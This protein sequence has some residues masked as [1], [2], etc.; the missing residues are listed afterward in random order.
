M[1]NRRLRASTSV[2]GVGLGPPTWIMSGNMSPVHFVRDR[3]KVS[4][5]TRSLISINQTGALRRRSLSTIASDN[6]ADA[7]VWLF[8][9]YTCD[10]G[11]TLHRETAVDTVYLQRSLL[12]VCTYTD[13]VENLVVLEIMEFMSWNRHKDSEMFLIFP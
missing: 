4:N 3:A 8:T 2:Y 6:L 10:C 13:S 1:K 5:E 7:F 11:E 12:L 9:V